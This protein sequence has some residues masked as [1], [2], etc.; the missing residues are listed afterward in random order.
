MANASKV[1]KKV[2]YGYNKYVNHNIIF[3]KTFPIKVNM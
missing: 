1:G 3:I 2:N